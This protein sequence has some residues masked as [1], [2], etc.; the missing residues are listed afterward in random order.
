VFGYIDAHGF[1]AVAEQFVDR[2]NAE[3]AAARAL[4]TTTF[5]GAVGRASLACLLDDDRSREPWHWLAEQLPKAL[6]LEETGFTGVY[7]VPAALG[8]A[9][10]SLEMAGINAERIVDY[11]KRLMAVD[12]LVFSPPLTRLDLR[13]CTGIIERLL[14]IRAALAEPARSREPE[15]VF[16]Q[17]GSARYL[18]YAYY[19][20]LSQGYDAVILGDA[21]VRSIRHARIEPTEPHSAQAVRFAEIYRHLSRN[22]FAPELV[23]FQRWFILRDYM[24]KSGRPAILLDHDVLVYPGL[25][26]LADYTRAFAML[27]TTWTNFIHSAEAVDGFC[28][29]LW[30]SYA[31]G[32]ELDALAQAD[33]LNGELRFSD[34]SLL[35]EYGARRPDQVC[36]FSTQGRWLGFDPN[37]RDSGGYVPDGNRKRI[38][39]I[40]GRPCCR[41]ADDGR[42]Q[43]F[44]TFH[45]QGIAK[46]LMECF[47]TITEPRYLAELDPL[48]SAVLERMGLPS[49]AEFP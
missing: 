23:C 7:L 29:F 28:R 8:L 46:P 25:L 33:A 5:S 45:F 36:R 34:M 43:A 24:A 4:A 44:R 13:G 39:F 35:L 37:F 40:D 3:P 16:I 18:K 20:A 38:E 49:I 42:L 48:D 19:Q 17:F 1:L 9:R 22:N 30:D 47:H 6:V 12:R 31:V 26:D 14:A 41:R 11:D 15:I 27:D 10:R 21:S 2:S 32:D